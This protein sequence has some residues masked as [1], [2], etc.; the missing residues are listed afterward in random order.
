MRAPEKNP[1][2]HT[3]LVGSTGQ[4]SQS[5][6][7][8]EEEQAGV[9]VVI[10]LFIGLVVSAKSTVASVLLVA[11]QLM[12]HTAGESSAEWVFLAITGMPYL[13]SSVMGIASTLDVTAD[14]RFGIKR[15]MYFRVVFCS[16]LLSLG[17]VLLAVLPD[18]VAQVILALV[19]CMLTDA[20]VYALLGFA[21]VLDPKYSVFMTFSMFFSYAVPMT[22]I[23]LL[24]F[25]PWPDW[26]LDYGVKWDLH[27]RLLLFAPSI[28]LNTGCAVICHFAWPMGKVEEAL[29][30]PSKQLD[31]GL[32]N[33]QSPKM[34]VAE[35]LLTF[36][37]QPYAWATFFGTVN[38]FTGMFLIPLIC[39]E[40]T[41][42]GQASLIE[43]RFWGEIVGQI[44]A[45]AGTQLGM[46][47]ARTPDLALQGA[48]TVLRQVVMIWIL[49]RLLAADLPWLWMFGFRFVDSFVFGATVV[50]AAQATP[51]AIRRVVMRGDYF[52]R[53]FGGVLGV[54]VAGCILHHHLGS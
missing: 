24:Q 46:I 51:V 15:A 17:A 34:G 26:R 47:A 30:K 6:E 29:H 52:Y 23:L 16:M 37:P 19:L 49:P 38:A 10:A 3:P 25:A 4:S 12:Y 22:T 54:A 7:E 44:A 40:E 20:V 48:L 21:A 5:E 8:K 50:Q 39:L 1:A 13:A 33:L 41:S 35:A 53:M 31:R 36:A 28:V 11:S 9:G 43:A 42:A 18:G 32:R 27:Q 45:T 14:E 2:E